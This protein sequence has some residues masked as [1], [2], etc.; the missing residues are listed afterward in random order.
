MQTVISGTVIS[1]R[2]EKSRANGNPF[3]IVKFF[4][5]EDVLDVLVNVADIVPMSGK[6]GTGEEVEIPV[7]VNPGVD[8]DNRPVLRVSKV[9]DSK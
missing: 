3:G 4:D 1:V 5:G 7:Y 2:Q 9:R 8:R 6:I